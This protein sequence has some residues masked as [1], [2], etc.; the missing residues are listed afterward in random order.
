[1][2]NLPLP[3]TPEWLEFRK[4]KI[5]A[6]DAPVI[7]GVS[8]WKTPYRLW[9]EKL[10]LV[11]GPSPSG[12]M[13]RGNVL[14]TVAREH[15]EKMTGI[16]VIP[17]VRLHA[18][19]SWMMASLDGLDASEQVMVEIKCP[20][21]EDHRLAEEGKIPEK[22]IPQLQHQLAVTGLKEGYYFSF[23]GT[24]GTLVEMKRDEGYIESLIEREQRFW[25]CLQNLEPPSMGEKDFV[26]RKD[27]VWESAAAEWLFLQQQLKTLKAREEGL[28]E[29]LIEMCDNQ[30]AIGAGIKVVRYATQGSIDYKGIPE[31][32]GVD[33]EKHRKKPKT[34]WRIS[35]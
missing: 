20:G 18:E 1:M 35:K 25:D 13:E 4:N 22:Y 23:D 9:E 3:G 31:L 12:A 34:C 15:F 24:K 14:E 5:G 7:M 29:L 8:P 6:S 28:R 27:P 30:S 19:L 10:S 21:K 32:Q 17:V 33:V 2:L 26:I 11:S 16:V